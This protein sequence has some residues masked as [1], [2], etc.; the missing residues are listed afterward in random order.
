MA[1]AKNTE[2]VEEVQNELVETVE[3]TT[4]EVVLNQPTVEREDPGNKTRAYRG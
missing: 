3:Q 1:K 2:S 4:P